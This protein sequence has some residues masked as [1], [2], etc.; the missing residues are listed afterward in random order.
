ALD[1]TTLFLAHHMAHQQ[2]LNALLQ[3]TDV[4]AITT[5]NASVDKVF[6][7]GLAAATTQDDVVEL[8]FTLEDALGQTYVYATGLL[9]RPEYRA[10]MTKIAGTQSRHRNLLGLVFAQQTVDDLFPASFARNDNPLPPDA[11]IT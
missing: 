10:T 1:T 6:K 4:P 3:T 11:I 5:P 8:L 9:T 7:P 2:A